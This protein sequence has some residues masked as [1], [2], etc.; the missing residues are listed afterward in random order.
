[1]REAGYP[2]LTFPEMTEIVIELI[3]RF[4]EKPS[5]AGEPTAA[6]VPSAIP[7]A[8]FD[9]T[10]ARLRSIPFKRRSALQSA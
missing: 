9:A 6:V 3:D 1:M 10:G 2:I 4:A 5:G 7:N 8:V